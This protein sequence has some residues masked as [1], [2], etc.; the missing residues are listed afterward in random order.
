MWITVCVPAACVLVRRLST[1]AQDLL[2]ASLFRNFLLAERIMAA[3]NCS[4]VSFPR[5]PPTHQHPMWQAW[6]LAAEMCLLQVCGAQGKRFQFH[7]RSRFRFRELKV[8]VGYS[9]A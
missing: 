3:S 2:V 4:P 5:L 8:E 1:V 6:D 9:H 7:C